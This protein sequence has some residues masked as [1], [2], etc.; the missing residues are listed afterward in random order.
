[1]KKKVFFDTFSENMPPLPRE[2]KNTR[3]LKNILPQD[4]NYGTSLINFHTF[5]PKIY[6][7]GLSINDSAGLVLYGKLWCK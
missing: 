3:P 1:M 2:W 4:V 5:T 6:F 7:S